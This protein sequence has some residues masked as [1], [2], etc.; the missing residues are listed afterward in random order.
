MIALPPRLV[1]E[2]GCGDADVQ[3]LDVP[4]LRDRDEQV[5]GPSDE[6][7]QPLAL[8][9]E[10]E[11]EAAR[12]VGLPHWRPVLARGARDPDVTALDLLEIPREVRHDGDRQVLDRAGRRAADDGR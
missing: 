6:R 10:D 11:G 4:E 9:A 3:G 8:G 5:A 2:D 7:P 12:Q 1:E